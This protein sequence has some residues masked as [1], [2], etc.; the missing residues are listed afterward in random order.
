MFTDEAVNL[1]KKVVFGGARSAPTDVEDDKVFKH[2]ILVQDRYLNIKD[3]IKKWKKYEEGLESKERRSLVEEASVQ[4]SQTTCRK[5]RQQ[6][7]DYSVDKR[8]KC[9]K[10]SKSCWIKR[11]EKL[12]GGTLKD[13]VVKVRRWSDCCWECFKRGG[14]ERWTFKSHSNPKKN[15]RCYLKGESGYKR[16][17]GS[18]KR[19]VSG[20]VLSKL[21][22]VR[23][24]APPPPPS[25]PSPPPP[26]PRSSP[27]PPISFPPPIVVGNP[28]PPSPPPPPPSPPPLPPSPPPPPPKLSPPTPPAPPLRGGKDMYADVLRD[29]YRFYAA[30]RSGV[31]P[32]PYEISWRESSHLSDYIVGGWYD[33]G[34]TLKLNFPLA[35][36][37]SIIGMGLV[38]FKDTYSTY[39]QL[40]QAKNTLRPAMDYL[41]DCLDMVAGTYVGAI[42]IPWIDHNYWGRASEQPQL[43]RPPAIYNSSMAAGDLYG[44]VS[45]ALSTGYLIYEN[46]DPLYADK[47]KRSAIYMYEWGAR[48][49]GK[50]SDYYT[51][52]TAATY[53]SSDVYDHL[54]WAAGWLY[55]IT[56]EQQYLVD[57]LSQWSKD[58]P[59]VYSGWDSVWGPHAA[60][61]VSLADR[62]NSVP[63]VD[64]YRDFLD[65]KFFKAWVDANGFQSIVKTPRGLAYPKFSIWG[66]LAFS[67]TASACATVVAKYTPD[68]ALRSRLTEF[69]RDQVHYAIGSATRSY[70]VGYGFRPADQPHHAGASC[71]DRPAPCGWQNF[72]DPNPNPQ[73]IRGA[74]VAGPGGQRV[75]PS[76]PDNSFVNVRS[77][78]VT[79]EVAV[80]YTA[81]LT[82]SAVGLLHLA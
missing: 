57:A 24:P 46:D 39:G 80:D 27:P 76:D 49:G 2:F 43:D 26:P 78:Y 58:F 3:A 54:A 51:R 4:S 70:L 81:G 29:T 75:N 22:S 6:K 21:D 53:P 50:Y 55:R 64:I 47:L 25:P 62:G 17:K 28:P 65:N 56:G 42:G 34:D 33:A 36:T 66:N 14:C 82:S 8:P 38:E 48:T 35:T 44:A 68:Q 60:H 15:G 45:A 32:Q 11:G 69:A 31:L 5:P 79:N 12:R 18:T 1:A 19:Y 30:Q 13:G 59:N 63:G 52:V 37:V 16:L 9:F 10:G 41:V 74:L 71:P 61:M 40:S 73:I 20:V 77:D 7:C 67:T 72:M 23:P